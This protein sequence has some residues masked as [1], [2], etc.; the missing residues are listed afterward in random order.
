MEVDL[1]QDLIQFNTIPD[2]LFD[3]PKNNNASA[4]EYTQDWEFTKWTALLPLI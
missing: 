2:L 1:N 4:V 3:D